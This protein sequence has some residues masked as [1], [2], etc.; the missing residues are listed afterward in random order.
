MSSDDANIAALTVPF[1]VAPNN[2]WQST[3]AVVPRAGWWTLTLTV[4]LSSTEAI[5]TAAHFRVW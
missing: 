5:V 2:A 4:Q 1:S 3:Y